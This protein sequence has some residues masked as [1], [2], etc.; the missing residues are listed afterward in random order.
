MRGRFTRSPKG[1]HKTAT[2]GR[3]IGVW[4]DEAC[5][6]RPSSVSAMPELV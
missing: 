5:T 3:E 6:K 1:I 2:F 4:E